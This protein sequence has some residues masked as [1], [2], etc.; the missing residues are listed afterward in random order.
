MAVEDISACTPNLCMQE[1]FDDFNVPEAIPLLALR[2]YLH[3]DAKGSWGET[4]YAD[5]A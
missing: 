5:E 1:Y 2:D 3:D 4:P